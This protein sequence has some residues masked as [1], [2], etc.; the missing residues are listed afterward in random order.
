MIL[1][2]PYSLLF[3]F[4]LFMKQ[5]K[6]ES[7]CKEYRKYPQLTNS[8]STLVTKTILVA[9]MFAEIPNEYLST[10]N[11]QLQTQLHN[12]LIHDYAF[13]R[14]VCKSLSELFLSYF[15]LYFGNQRQEGQIIFHTVSKDIPPG[16][17][18]DEMNQISVTLKA[19]ASS[20]QSKSSDA[21]EKRLTKYSRKA[22]RLMNVKT[23]CM[24]IRLRTRCQKNLST[25]S[26]D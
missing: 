5:T 22:L 2:P 6:D 23:K 8:V 26:T 24:V 12:E 14:S 3:L 17:P 21:I 15:D 18:V 11:R 10:F 4:I 19:N 7:Y 20:K 25:R 1:L 13:P 16:V 9:L